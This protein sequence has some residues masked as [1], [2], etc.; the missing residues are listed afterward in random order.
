[1]SHEG[2]EKD[3]S[4]G[5]SDAAVSEAVIDHDRMVALATDPH[6]G[7]RMRHVQLIAISGSIGSALFVSIGNPLTDAGPLG[8]LLGVAI[9][10]IVVWAA[11]NCLIEMTSLLPVDGGF[12]TFA[13]RFVDRSFGTALGWNY[14]ITQLALICFELTAINV[15]VEYWTLSLHPAILIGVGLVLLAIVNL[16]SVRCN[17][18]HDKYGFRFWKNPGPFVGSS[19]KARLTGIFDSVVWSTFAWVSGSYPLA[20][21]KHLPPFLPSLLRVALLRVSLLRVAI[22]PRSDSP[23]HNSGWQSKPSQQQSLIVGP[24]YI[25]LIGGEVRNP[26]RILPRAF[27]S[28]IYRIVFFYLTGAL[29]VGI[30][31]ASDDPSLLGAIAA[32]APGAAKSPYVISMNRLGIPVLPSLVNALILVSIFSTANSFT[33]TASRA[34]YGL[35][36]RGQ[37]PS[38]LGRLNGQGVPTYLRFRAGLKAQNLFNVDFLPVRGYLQPLSGYWLLVWSP[39]VFIF[40]GYFVFLPSAWDTPSFIFAYGSVF[41]F[42]LILVLSKTWQVVG[43]K[44]SLGW[45]RTKEM[46]FVGDIKEIGEMTEASEEYRLSKPRTWAQKI[47]DFFF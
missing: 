10:S 11:S 43:R 8:L 37:A 40:N 6:R 34:M 19:F 44:Q 3:V 45:I 27:N 1:M 30:V 24:D 33:F 9:W 39:V 36:Q 2:K 12:V 29:C 5:S 23:D 7:L 38:I 28:T 18:L 26:R 13:T 47:S 21:P 20:S 32:G 31:A 46:D 35:S 4:T 25:S 17:P 42:L 15:I 16:Y 22:P 14:I 41:I